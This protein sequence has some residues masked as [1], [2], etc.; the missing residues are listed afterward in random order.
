[1]IV[2]LG[3]DDVDRRYYAVLH[4]IGCLAELPWGHEP[5]DCVVMLCDHVR[6]E[7]VRSAVS[8]ELVRTNVEWVSVAGEGAEALHDAIDQASVTIGRQKAVGDG[9][10]MTSWHTDERSVEAMAELACSCFGGED[11]V[12]I[13]VIGPEADFQA[14]VQALQKRLGDPPITA[15]YG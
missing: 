15:S 1:M 10:P 5:F 6:A 4:R 7:A 13:V 14:A 8:Y 11:Q 9:S 12:L 3:Q 2:E